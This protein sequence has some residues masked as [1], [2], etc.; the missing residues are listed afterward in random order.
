MN[1][2]RDEIVS[3]I[4]Q[5][6][7]IRKDEELAE[8]TAWLNKRRSYKGLEPL[9][10]ALVEINLLEMSVGG[11][12]KA[13]WEH[14]QQLDINGRPNGDHSNAAEEFG[15]FMERWRAAHPAFTLEIARNPN[16]RIRW[17]LSKQA[18]TMFKLTFGGV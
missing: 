17:Y 3:R 4:R 15:R 13:A 2:P 18:A 5:L 10:D 7:E 11:G 9:P 14:V 6:A 1:I 12:L 16:S 8:A